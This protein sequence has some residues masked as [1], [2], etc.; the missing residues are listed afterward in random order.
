MRA[1]GVDSCGWAG[2]RGLG[3]GRCAGRT[4]PRVSGAEVRCA[5]RP[6]QSRL[7][8]RPQESSARPFDHLP[9]R[10]DGCFLWDGRRESKAQSVRSFLVRK[11]TPGFSGGKHWKSQKSRMSIATSPRLRQRVSAPPGQS[12]HSGSTR[13]RQLFNRRP[14]WG[15]FHQSPRVSTRRTQR[16]TSARLCSTCRSLSH[17][18][19]RQTSSRRSER[20]QG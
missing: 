1:D 19:R 15:Y 11:Q 10:E 20:F 4:P 5:S 12:V 3:N 9:Q 16:S 14:G 8:K 13:M 2:L 18:P 17:S 7:S 6:R